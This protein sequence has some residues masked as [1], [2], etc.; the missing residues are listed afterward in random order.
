MLGQII[1]LTLTH[2]LKN[3][4]P[5]W[6]MHHMRQD[7]SLCGTNAFLPCRK[8]SLNASARHRTL[9]NAKDAQNLPP[10]L[11]ASLDRRHDRQ[12]QT[13]RLSRKLRAANNKHVNNEGTSPILLMITSSKSGET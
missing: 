2:E 10:K 5:R 4:P 6:I 1:L 3:I 8:V 7:M 13:F 9:P 11:D 12:L